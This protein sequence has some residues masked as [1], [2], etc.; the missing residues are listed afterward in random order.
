MH[1]V[2]SK[3]FDP[4]SNSWQEIEVLIDKKLN[5]DYSKCKW[6]AI[7][8]EFTGLYPGRD[9]S[10]VWTLCSEDENGKMRIEMLYT[11]HDDADISVLS[12]LL[13]S[14]K[15]KLFWYARADLAFL[16]QLTGKRVAQPM[17]DV[18]IAA[19]LARTHT[20]ITIDSMVA[21]YISSTEKIIDKTALMSA[22]WVTDYQTWSP[23]VIQY[24]VND[25]VYLRFLADKIKEIAKLANREDVIDAANRA[26]PDLGIIYAKGFYKDVFTPGY[27]DNEMVPSYL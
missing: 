23:E 8:G 16:Y 9:K 21:N 11:Y 14:D 27:K 19:I 15:E 25:V 5:Y 6:F 4:R 1:K 3:Y 26:L 18:K 17:F 20:Q 7:D 12:E 13:T 10:T 24:N 22:D 2:T